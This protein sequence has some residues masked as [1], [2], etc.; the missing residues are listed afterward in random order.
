MI[1][2]ANLN[3]YRNEG[4]ESEVSPIIPMSMLGEDLAADEKS[5]DI[6][7]HNDIT[8][9]TLLKARKQITKQINS[10]KKIILQNNLDINILK[11]F[12]INLHINSNGG[13]VL[14]S[15]GMYDFIQSSPVPIYTYVEGICASAA[16]IISVAGHKR[17][18]TRSS[19][20]MIHQLS[21][22]FSGKH[23]EFVDEKINLD[24]M[25]STI[26]Q[27]YLENT[28]M[29]KVKLLDLLKRDLFLKIDK[30]IEYGFVDEMI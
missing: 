26:K 24:L 4:E 15:F 12:H 23:Q 9:E 30:C 10:Y 27:I 13:Y 14:D 8:T 29:K 2:K 20:F 28:K 7:L 25:M 19:L 22:W 18:M 17:F 5:N 1:Y 3:Q 16:T 6:Y 11:Q 21:T